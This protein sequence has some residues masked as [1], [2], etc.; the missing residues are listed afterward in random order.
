MNKAKI[1]NVILNHHAGY[2]KA[3]LIIKVTEK[4]CHV[5][6]IYNGDDKI[7]VSSFYTN[8]VKNN[9]MFEVIGYIDITKIVKETLEKYY[10]DDKEI[11]KIK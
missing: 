2:K 1:G 10:K 11:P 8:D 9:D 6:G 7:N 3:D 5:V 4:F